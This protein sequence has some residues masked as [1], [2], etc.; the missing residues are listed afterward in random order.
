MNELKRQAYLRTMGIQ[1]YFPRVVLQGAKPSPV[2]DMSA[3]K[4]LEPAA[5]ELAEQVDNGVAG[6][7]GA[8][9]EKLDNLDA[10]NAL[11]SRPLSRRTAKVAAIDA[12]LEDACERPQAEDK[13]QAHNT[14]LKQAEPEMV[15]DSELRFDLQYFKINKNLAVI[16]E[17]PRQAAE[18]VNKESL[19]LMAAILKALGQGVG[20]QRLQAEA[21]SWPLATGYSMKNPPVI[22][23]AKALSGFLQMRQEVDGFANLLVFAGQVEE[24]LLSQAPEGSVRDFQCDKGYF[25]TVT[26]SLHSMLA[27]PSLKKEVWQQLQALRKRVDLTSRV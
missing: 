3:Y 15:Q 2:Y 12:D 8:D 25:I 14:A 20:D 11:R 6:D 16:N 10:I 22:E 4:Q 23:A 1:T 9:N 5:I 26:S 18:Q 13:Q 24:V 7:Q 17:V 27:V 21:F 19:I